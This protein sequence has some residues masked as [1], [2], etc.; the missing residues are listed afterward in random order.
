MNHCKFSKCT[1]GNPLYLLLCPY[2]NRR[3][4]S[5]HLLPE[6][7]GCGQKVKS[8]ERGKRFADPEPTKMSD[9]EKELAQARLHQFL[10]HKREERKPQQKKKS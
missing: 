1:Q 10:K 2:C 5:K 4:C 8:V 9:S 7:H 3:Y 6:I